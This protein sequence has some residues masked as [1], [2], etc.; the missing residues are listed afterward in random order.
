MLIS[1][2][3]KKLIIVKSS[4]ILQTACSLVMYKTATPVMMKSLS[5]NTLGGSIQ[6]EYYLLGDKL[7]PFT[8]EGAF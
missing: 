4:T 7:S 1:F 8:W 6:T 5:I 3:L 2:I